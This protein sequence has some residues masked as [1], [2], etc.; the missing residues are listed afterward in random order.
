MVDMEAISSQEF[1]GLSAFG[2]M[3]LRMGRSDDASKTFLALLKLT[4]NAKQK[5]WLYKNLAV[6]YMRK[7]EYKIALDYIRKAIGDRMLKSDEA[8]LYLLRAESLWQT[9]RHAE[10]ENSIKQ[11]YNLVS[12]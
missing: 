2:Y 9:S 10:A 6:A 11:Y 4:E 1:Q 5:N 12:E 7:K 3:L 8:F